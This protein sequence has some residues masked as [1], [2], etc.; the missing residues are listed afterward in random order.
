M[1]AFSVKSNAMIS[2]FTNVV[3]ISPSPRS[4]AQ[5]RRFGV[6]HALFEEK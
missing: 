1:R 2:M 4:Y 3:R 6:K 5:R